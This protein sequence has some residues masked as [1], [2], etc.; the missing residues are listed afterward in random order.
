MSLPPTL[1]DAA[2]LI[3]SE[4]L[5][6]KKVSLTYA[7][8]QAWRDGDISL[9]GDTLP[10]D[11]PAR[12]TKPKLCRPSDMPKRSPGTG[13][14]RTALVHAIAH[15]ELNAIDLA[16]DIVAR[17]TALDF[18]TTFYDDW[19]QIAADEAK[20]FAMLD[21][22]LHELDAAY[23]D[24]LAHDGLWQAAQST[25]HDILERLS[26]VPM[27]LEARGLDTTPASV[28]RLTQNNDTATANIM[29][30]IGAEEVNHVAA[31]VKWFEYVCEN[32]D[33]EP[34]ATF[35]SLAAKNFKGRLKPP[36][37]YSARDLANMNRAYYEE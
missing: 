13:L 25:H 33:L 8:A 3:L 19:V 28:K 6:Q 22:R 24:F 12:P 20:H 23:G 29:S 32:R 16:W 2:C 7:Y 9:V 4:P 31:G 18:P 37:N 14:R 5:P 21:H 15:I 26:L 17:F 30:I 36:F 34:I 1:S 10:P 35:K 11:R 27:I